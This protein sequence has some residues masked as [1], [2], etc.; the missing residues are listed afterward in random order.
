MRKAVIAVA[1]AVAVGIGV[2]VGALAAS[3]GSS[4]SSAS[5]A[6]M[7]RNSD[8]WEIDQIEKN[9]H[10]ATTRKDLPLMMSLYAPN[11]T[12]T[13]AGTIASGKKAIREFWTTS[14]SFTHDW[15]SDTPAYKVRITLNGDRGTL[16][17]EC[18]YVTR[19]GVMAAV[20]AADAEVARIGG[21]WLVT[22]LAGAST[23]LRP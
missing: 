3:G 20:T 16:Y 22:N 23:T 12:F 13:F 8:L 5:E 14:K 2:L 1:V 4:A 11:A 21:R 7:R 19:K 17:F 18:H 9:F 6:Q 10:R 15:V